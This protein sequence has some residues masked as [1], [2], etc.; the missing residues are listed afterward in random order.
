MCHSYFKV[1]CQDFRKIYLLFLA[2]LVTAE[3]AL[4]KVLK[5]TCL[6]Y[7]LEQLLLQL[8]S[9]T[10]KKNQYCMIPFNFLLSF[11]WPFI[12]SNGLTLTGCPIS[13]HPFWT[14]VNLLESG[15]KYIHT[16]LLV[17]FPS[18][19]VPYHSVISIYISLISSL[20]CPLT[21]ECRGDNTKVL[22]GQH[23]TCP[24]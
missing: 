23:F 13:H 3:K 1:A 14:R 5:G 15:L 6:H 2:G 9:S 17:S 22:R 7:R 19:R 24:T 12:R 20:I 18:P 21:T 4:I 10:K 8:V 16:G 11:V